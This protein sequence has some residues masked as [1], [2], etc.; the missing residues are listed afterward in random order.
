MPIKRLE[1]LLKANDDRG[2][3]E[4]VRH[5]RAM[6]ELLRVLRD[7]LPGDAAS[8]INAANIRDDSVLVILANSPAW[9]AK[10]R[11][12][13]DSLMTAARNAGIEVRSCTI[14]VSRG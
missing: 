5:A 6:D 2:L 13:A 3:G 7:A 12:E 8:S 1:N 11:F 10:L 9:A 14:R 4:I